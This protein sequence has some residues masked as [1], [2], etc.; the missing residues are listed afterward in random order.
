MV[1]D[2]YT[3]LLL[4]K[5]DIFN[6]FVQHGND[7]WNLGKDQS[8]EDVMDNTTIEYNNMVKQKL[9]SQTNPKD[10][11]KIAL[12][13]L[14]NELQHGKKCSSSGNSGK[15]YAGA[16]SGGGSVDKEWKFTLDPWCIVKEV[17]TK[18]VDGKTW[19]WCLHHK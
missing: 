13:T 17:Q 14:N 9:W 11:K 5:N 19:H 8:F 7:E 12:T 1:L 18:A 2:T 15:S 4:D 16:V 3:A 10:T 6:N